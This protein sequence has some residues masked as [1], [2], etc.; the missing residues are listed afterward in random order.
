MQSAD[1]G[2]VFRFNMAI[3]AGEN[4]AR[5]RSRAAHPAFDGPRPISE[6]QPTQLWLVV[7]SARR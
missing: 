5:E 1:V 7:A 2:E 3:L 6:N 4:S